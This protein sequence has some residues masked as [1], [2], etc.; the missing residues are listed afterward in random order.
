MALLLFF[1]R[2]KLFKVL[3]IQFIRHPFLFLTFDQTIKK[4]NLENIGT[5][6]F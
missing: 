5:P 2:N 6:N 3:L 1:K 4:L